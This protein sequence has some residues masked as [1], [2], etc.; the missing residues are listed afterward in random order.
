[1]YISGEIT[2]DLRDVEGMEL[3]VMEQVLQIQ[4]HLEL[5]CLLLYGNN[6]INL[7]ILVKLGLNLIKIRI[8]G[9]KIF[10]PVL[11]YGDMLMDMKKNNDHVQMDIMYLVFMNG[12]KFIVD[13]QKLFQRKYRI[14][15]IE[16]N[17]QKIFYYRI[18]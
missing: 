10:E 2:G 17:F 5:E 3:H 15:I 9:K 12:D 11:I 6:I 1:M 18:I 7:N 14:K 4:T 13:G 8:H 16:T